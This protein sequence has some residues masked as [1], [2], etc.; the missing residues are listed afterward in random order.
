M[1][2]VA[3]ASLWALVGVYWLAVG[4]AGSRDGVG[5]RLL[6]GV[7][8]GL[9][10]AGALYG[11]VGSR[12]GLQQGR[13]GVVVAAIG[14]ALFAAA[15]PWFLNEWIRGDSERYVWLIHQ[16]YPCSSMGGGP[17]M[18]WVFGTSALAAV[19]AFGHAV[20]SGLTVIRV[21]AGLGLGSGLLGATAIAMFPDP[22][23]FARILGCL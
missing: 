3:A 18:L 17:G 23:V 9:A 20:T 10:L 12:T 4:S 21:V 11:I 1:I 16:G 22:A 5:F 15:G 2:R 14:V 13:A 8:T 19:G 7:F 6:V